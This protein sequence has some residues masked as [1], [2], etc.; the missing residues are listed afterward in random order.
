MGTQ[1]SRVEYFSRQ[2]LRTRDLGDEQAYH[3]EMRRRHNV[4]GHSWGIDSGLLLT[5]DDTDRVFVQPGYAIDGYGRELVV[6]AVLAVPDANPRIQRGPLDVWL[7]YDT[8]AD[9]PV[10]RADDGCAPQN[11]GPARRL[12]ETARVFTHPTGTVPPVPVPGGPSRPAEVPAGDFPFTP[13]RAAPDTPAQPWPVFL[14]RITY[15]PTA[16]DPKVIAWNIDLSDRVYAGLVGQAVVA[17]SRRL[18]TG[19]RKNT[20]A[21]PAGALLQMGPTRKGDPYQF[22]VYV[23]DP[24]A[25]GNDVARLGLGGDGSLTFHGP[26]TRVEGDL[27]LDAG[28]A[29]EFR[30]NGAP[31]PADAQPVMEPL[32]PWRVYHYLRL[33]DPP[34][35]GVAANTGDGFAEELR[36][37]MSGALG[38]GTNSVV[39]GA[40]SDQGKFVPCLAVGSDQNVTVYGNLIVQGEITAKARQDAP[41]PFNPGALNVTQA[42]QNV[43]DFI[44]PPGTPADVVLD[45]LLQD[46]GGRQLVVNKLLLSQP[47]VDLF[48]K[49]D[50]LAGLVDRALQGATLPAD[51]ANVAKAVVAEL[52]TVSA[53]LNPIADGLLGATDGPKAVAAS[54]K[55]DPA[56][57]ADPTVLTDDTKATTLSAALLK[58]S[59]V[60]KAAGQVVTDPTILGNFV[61]GL[62][63]DNAGTLT[64]AILADAVAANAKARAAGKTFPNDASRAVHKA[65]AAGLIDATAPGTQQL[66]PLGRV[67]FEDT[68]LI[69]AMVAE[70]NNSAAVRW[71][72]FVGALSTARLGELIDALLQPA[73]GDTRMT[74]LARG[75]IVPPAVLARFV[76]QLTTTDT[77]GPPPV[78]ALMPRLAA[79]L[80]ANV[81]GTAAGQ[82]AAN[83]RMTAVA[84]ALPNA[85]AAGPPA[86]TLEQ[87][88][89]PFVK[90]LTA[91]ADATHRSARAA[92]FLAALIDF[93]NTD[94]ATAPPGAEQRLGMWAIDTTLRVDLNDPIPFVPPLALT[95]ARRVERFMQFLHDV[96]KVAPT[97][98]DGL[99]YQAL[100][101]AFVAIP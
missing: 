42:A 101:K 82:T 23:P 79:A 70:V 45:R 3:L 88:L 55:F 61:S 89:S 22:A 36:I 63:P 68:A 5:A 51:K 84:A 24:A 12:V 71:G 59:A 48:L 93:P 96:P 1:P 41:P 66:G 14:G 94:A 57:F 95:G 80:F 7:T 72:D 31:A 6:G 91:D 64:A 98:T 99:I 86:I 10:T 73:P 69:Q 21:P 46:P 33:A 32:G 19:G 9:D 8:R 67:L 2:Y 38:G 83:D 78:P 26:E 76:A 17:P 39:V 50:N 53:T 47:A 4:A 13:D 74:A 87:L 58:R 29:L 40:W 16:A 43:S 15:E 85:D 30:A 27:V 75:L 92:A 25:P 20:S 52:V 100:G 44:V 77:A 11:G 56:G 28:G 35:A 37:V 90:G 34:Q 60:A 49:T 65:F 18:D 62:T 97:K 54:A 81:A